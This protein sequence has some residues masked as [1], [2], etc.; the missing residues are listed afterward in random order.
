MPGGRAQLLEGGKS[1]GHYRI[2]K[3][4]GAGGMGEVYLAE[5]PVLER[6][7]ALKTLSPELAQNRERIRRIV[8]EAKAASA[9]NHPN[10]LTIYEI[11]FEQNIRFIAS[12]YIEGRTLRDV[13]KQGGLPLAVTLNISIQIASALEAEHGALIVHRDLK[14]ENVM[15]R[16]DGLVKIL[17]F[18]VAKLL[19]R[20]TGSG[21]DS[22]RHSKNKPRT[23]VTAILSGP[24]SDATTVIQT[25]TSQERIIGTPYY[26]SPEQAEGKAVDT[27]SDIFSFGILLFEMLSGRKAFQGD[28]VNEVISAIVHGKPAALSDAEAPRKLRDTVEKCL[29]KNR[30]VRYQTATHLLVDLKDSQ[31]YVESIDGSEHAFTAAS[32]ATMWRR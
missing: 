29:R 15:V 3:K 2:L 24:L 10:I 9:L 7:A 32:V 13:L 21:G 23:S 27:R 12:E 20:T 1:L 4:L 19:E 22:Q 28:T 25:G 26:M 5:D 6:L 17:D 8:Q 18:G 31:Q 14:P 16:E 30:K 11:G